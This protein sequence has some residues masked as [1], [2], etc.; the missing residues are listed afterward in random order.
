[1]LEN[2]KGNC[3]RKKPNLHSASSDKSA[4]KRHS[5]TAYEAEISAFII[6]LPEFLRCQVKNMNS[7]KIFKYIF[8]KSLNPFKLC[9]MASMN[10][11]QDPE[12]WTV[13]DAPGDENCWIYA[14]L[15]SAF[16]STDAR[17]RMNPQE[18]RDKIS[19][20][21]RRVSRLPSE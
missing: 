9:Q 21:L 13:V 18:C 20:L 12:K 17:I 19:D 16:Y 5:Q 6:L 15:T 11:V 2:Q 1:M 8:N 3:A 4:K 7:F 14:T 10:I